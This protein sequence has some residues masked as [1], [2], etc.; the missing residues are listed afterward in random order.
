MIENI[1]DKRERAILQQDLKYADGLRIVGGD[2]SRVDKLNQQLQKVVARIEELEGEIEGLRPEKNYN[3]K[4]QP[5]AL[6]RN[7]LVSM[8]RSLA[9]EIHDAVKQARLDE[10][11]LRHEKA[12]PLRDK[13]DSLDREILQFLADYYSTLNKRVEIS[14]ELESFSKV[15]GNISKD[16]NLDGFNAS[17]LTPFKKPMPRN[18]RAANEVYLTQFMRLV[19]AASPSEINLEWFS[20][21]L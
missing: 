8:V 21:R 3:T 17:P 20:R 7:D 4:H 12:D 15:Y 14:Q 11:E 16:Y 13:V 19:S 5:L 10:Y 6:E 18:L 1:F 9:N 2:V